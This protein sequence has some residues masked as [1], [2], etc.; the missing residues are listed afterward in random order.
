MFK[1]IALTAFLGGA[2][3]FSMTTAA[4]AH[5][6]SGGH[7]RH[8]NYYGGGGAWGVGYFGGYGGYDGS[9]VS[10]LYAP[11]LQF[12]GFDRVPGFYYAPPGV[13][14]E[15]GYYLP[16]L[17]DSFGDDY[18]VTYG[19]RCNGYRDGWYY[20]RDGGRSGSYRHNAD[21]DDFYV[22]HGYWYGVPV[23]DRY[24]DAVG[25]CDN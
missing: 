24:D 9:Y 15:H 22:R 23:C 6:R 11:R 20:G 18:F 3:L 5:D 7:N 2:L 25:Y 4:T 13:G 19:S 8:D 10:P 12:R 17:A 1:R 14:A 21:C 16:Y